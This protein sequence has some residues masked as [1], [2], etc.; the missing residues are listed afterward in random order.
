MGLAFSVSARELVIYVAL[1][2]TISPEDGRKQLT[3][4]SGSINKPRNNLA[5]PKLYFS[6]QLSAIIERYM[7]Q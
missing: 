4:V 7:H 6:C 3:V 2:S 5:Q 1:L